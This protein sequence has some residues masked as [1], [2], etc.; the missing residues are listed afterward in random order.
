[1]DME[2][3]QNISYGTTGYKETEKRK[4]YVSRF[5]YTLLSYDTPTFSPKIKGPNVVRIVE[6][7]VGFC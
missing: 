4:K 5:F 3:I 7:R 6:R 1:M 2:L